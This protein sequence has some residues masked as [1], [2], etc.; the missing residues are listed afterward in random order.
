M[1]LPLHLSEPN[2]EHRVANFLNISPTGN[3]IQK[4]DWLGLFSDE[5]IQ[6]KPW[7]TAADVMVDLIKRKLEL[8]KKGKDMVA[9]MHEMEAYYPKQKNKRERIT[10]TFIKYGE[11]GGFT[12]IAQTVGLPAALGAELLLTDRLPITGCHIPTHPAVYPPVL[13]ALKKMGYK[14]VE[15]IEEIK[16]T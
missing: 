1:F 10:S 6:S 13:K 12:A 15:K 11:P 4:M 14:F 2:L 7:Y 9:I 5:I 3:I 8:P 16:S